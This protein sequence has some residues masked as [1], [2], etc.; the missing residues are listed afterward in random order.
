[1]NENIKKLTAAAVSI[2]MAI[3]CVAGC[4]GKKAETAQKQE[5]RAEVIKAEE[6]AAPEHSKTAGNSPEHKKIPVNFFTEKTKKSALCSHQRTDIIKGGRD[7]RQPSQV[8]YITFLL[9]NQGGILL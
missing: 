4:G 3:A 6:M 7:I 5:I 1:M 8:K 9:K 2:S